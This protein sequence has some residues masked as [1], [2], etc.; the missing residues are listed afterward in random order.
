MTNLLRCLRYLRGPRAFRVLRASACLLALPAALTA[1]G[2]IIHVDL[3]YRAPVDG[4]PRP[5]FSPKGEQVKLTA[6][7]MGAK[8]P[9]GA[10]FPAKKGLIKVGPDKN[11]WV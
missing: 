6:L 10:I 9:S 11:S 2:Q 3:A 8:L 4:E 7:P 5:N 1:Q